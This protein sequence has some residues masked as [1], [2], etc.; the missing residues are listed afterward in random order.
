MSATDLPI[1]ATVLPW[2]VAAGVALA[3]AALVYAPFALAD[4]PAPVNAT[5][6][7]RQH[8]HLAEG[9]REHR[10]L[11]WATTMTLEASPTAYEIDVALPY[12]AEP[13]SSDAEGPRVWT[14]LTVNG[15]PV[16][17]HLLH[18]S[19]GTLAIVHP[20]SELDREAF[21]AGAN[22]LAVTVA[23]ER[24]A[25]QPGSANVTVGPLVAE[26]Q[27]LDADGD[28][29]PDAEQPVQGFH[30][31]ALAALA[32]LGLGGPAGWVVHR[33]GPGREGSP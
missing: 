31:G 4:P 28:A 22:E 32:G 8:L 17:R 23:I 16:H 29:V 11:S 19:T 26:A 30:T 27:P 5:T 2:L 10:E 15:E 3:V 13:S 21:H 18:A 25:D 1:P 24:A 6:G 14:N 33:Q 12:A 7:D 20:A 9:Q